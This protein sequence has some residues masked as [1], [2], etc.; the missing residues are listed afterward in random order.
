MNLSNSRLLPFVKSNS[1][2]F[3]YLAGLIFLVWVLISF[4][5]KDHRAYTA[6]GDVEWPQYQHDAQN[7]GYT[8]VQVDPSYSFGWAKLDDD[9]DNTITDFVSQPN[10]SITDS[11]SMPVEDFIP[12]MVVSNNVQPVVAQDSVF[13][14]S[15]YGKAYSFDA[16]DGSTNW[17]YQTGAPIMGS[18]AYESSVV[19]FGSLDGNIYGFNPTNGTLLWTRPVNGPV[20]AHLKVYGG[21]LYIGT[22]AGWFYKINVTDGSIAWQYRVAIPGDAGSPFGGS[23]IVAPAAIA[24]DNSKV[25][26]LSENMRT[27]ALNVS[28]GS[29]SWISDVMYG[30]STVLSVPVIH[31]G[32]LYLYTHSSLL[33][34]EEASTAVED[35]YDT[36][37][38]SYSGGSYTEHI[39]PDPGQSLDEA[40]IEAETTLL[41]AYFD[42]DPNQQVLSAFDLADGSYPYLER[43]PMGRVSGNNWA[44]I[45]PIST[46]DGLLTYWRSSF[47]SLF[48]DSPAFG[49]DFCPDLSYLDTTTGT[50]INIST[51]VS[52]GK[53]CPELDNGFL[54]TMGGDRLYMQNSF[55]GTW[56]IDMSAG[57]SGDV[58]GTL[59]RLTATFAKWDYGDFRGWGYDFIYYGNDTAPPETTI[60]IRPVK[61]FDSTVYHGGIVPAQV[62]GQKILVLNENGTDVGM[63]AGVVVINGN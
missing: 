60:D 37:I 16:L 17:S 62:N 20:S 2:R 59:R 10:S 39:T 38:R 45:P 32:A 7:S 41:R 52:S 43:I 40:R 9:D 5:N 33:G 18:A 57:E 50:R 55:R 48:Q 23:A 8:S 13:I 58:E 51:D 34:A 63:T 54:L 15:M 42:T 14:G 36:N 26:F 29:V 31:D 30:Q 25:F 22:R 11:L 28:N 19:M 27:Y 47:G 4:S 56:T 49:T 53:A 44:P 24:S 35:L 3:F 1:T 12:N 6:G 21:Y 46:P 61:P